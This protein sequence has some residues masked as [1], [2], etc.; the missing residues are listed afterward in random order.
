MS[1]KELADYIKAYFA[2]LAIPAEVWHRPTPP[3]C[4]CVI[5]PLEAAPQQAQGQA[6]YTPDGHR[7]NHR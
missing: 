3:M 4:R 2:M 5:R 7:T 6:L 1:D